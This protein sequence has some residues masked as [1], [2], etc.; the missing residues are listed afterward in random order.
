MLFK[1][2]SASLA[3]IEAYPVEVEVD[4]SPRFSPIHHRRPARP[5]RPGEQGA[6]PGRPQELRL[7][8]HGPQDHHQP[9][10]GR[11]EEGG[12]GLR[13]AHRPGLPGRAS[14]S[15]LPRDCAITCSSASWPWTGGSSPCPA[16]CRSP[17][18]SRS[19]ASGAS[20][21]P[22][23]TSRRPRSCPAST[24]TASTISSRSSASSP[25]SPDIHPSA[26][27][28]EDSVDAARSTTSISGRSK[29]NSTSSGPS[30]WPRP[31]A[32][33]VLLI[34]PPGRRKDHAGPAAPDHPPAHD[35]RRDDRRDPGLQR[36]R[37]PPG[38]RGREPSAVP[39]A[40]PYDHRR[41]ASS[42]AESSRGRAR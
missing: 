21:C 8:H 9:R 18:S 33:N 40:A 32:H 11:P 16:S 14:G 12:L 10:P 28:P 27:R 17:S 5:G 42:A 25:E 26:C 38:C 34:G 29:A 4:I 3:G 13:P 1:I 35:L 39:G 2:A 30:R 19:R 6:R 31:G 20:S 41:R 22:T 15:S 36:G 37:A 24:S 7:R 23:P